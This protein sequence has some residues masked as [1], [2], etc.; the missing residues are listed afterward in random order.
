VS[1]FLVQAEH[2]ILRKLYELRFITFFTIEVFITSMP[3][4]IS[5]TVL[6]C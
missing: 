6:L 2:Q 3:M 1:Y 5:L 4:F